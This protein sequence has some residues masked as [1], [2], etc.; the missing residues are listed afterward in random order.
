LRQVIF[1]NLLPKKQQ[2]L[3]KWVMDKIINVLHLDGGIQ[4]EDFESASSDEIVFVIDTSKVNET[5]EL[6]NTTLNNSVV[7]EGF[8]NWLRIEAFTLKSIGG[9]KFFAKENCIDSSVDFKGIQSYFF[10]QV[11]KTYLQKPI[12]EIDRKF[13]FD[14]LLATFDK[15]V[16]EDEL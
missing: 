10:M 5:L 1:G 7:T 14:G 11:Y 3:Q 4:M 8:V 9:K 15:G 6:V 2:K 13:Y 12:E 16:F